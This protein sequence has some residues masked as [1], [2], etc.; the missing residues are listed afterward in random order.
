MDMMKCK[1]C[2]EEF[3]SKRSTAKYCSD[4]CRQ[5]SHRKVSVTEDDSLALQNNDKSLSVTCHK[6]DKPED[7]SQC[8]RLDIPCKCQWWYSAKSWE[9]VDSYH[10]SYCK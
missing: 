10:R 8:K 3:Q 5:S 9:H 1:R 4:A 7:C 6:I 2:E